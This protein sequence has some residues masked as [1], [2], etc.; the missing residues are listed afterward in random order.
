VKVLAT[1]AGGQLGRALVRLGAVGR[2]RAELDV[3][4]ARAVAAA[5]DELRPDV[6]VNAAAYTAVDR[7]EREAD[8]AF[9]VN[10]RGAEVVAAACAARGLGL[11]HVS[12][13]YVFDGEKPSPYVED[14]ALHPVSVYG[15][16][17]AAGEAAV[18]RAHPGA[19]VVRTSWLFSADGAN[20]VLTMLRLARERPALRVV[21][22]QRGCPTYAGDLARAILSLCERRAPGGAYHVAGDGPTTWHGLALAVVDEAARAGRAPRVPVEAIATADY[23]TAARRPHMSILDTAKVR[24]LGVVPAPWLDG[25]RAVVRE[26]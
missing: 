16:S 12:T 25:V 6:V 18:L 9:A 24:A 7:A 4:D 14:D 8:A 2:T 22:D 26:S 1:G 13:D 17:K 5:L 23:P 19:L 21:A 11:V 15:A 20:F 10:G 3:T